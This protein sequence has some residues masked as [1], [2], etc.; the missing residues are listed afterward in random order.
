MFKRLYSNMMNMNIVLLF[1]ICITVVLI[2]E[3]LRTAIFFAFG[4]GDFFYILFNNLKEALGFF[5]PIVERYVAAL[6]FTGSFYSTLIKPFIFV[7][8]ITI[9]A[10]LIQFVLHIFIYPPKRFSTT[11]AVFYTSIISF[12]LLNLIPYV[13]GIFFSLVLLASTVS[14]VS[15]INGFSVF[16]GFM[17]FLA[18]SVMLGAV[19]FFAFI[20]VLKVFSLF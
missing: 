11:L 7:L 13:G 10:A 17:L 8:S 12:Y 3:I 20:S 14:G 2:V 6:M 5:D 16:K 1:I 15:K 18:P 4:S 19:S 9:Y